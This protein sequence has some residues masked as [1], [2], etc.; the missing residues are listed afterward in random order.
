VA[1]PNDNAYIEALHSNL[2][3]DVIDRFESESIFHAQM[4]ID[5]YYKWY[6][7][8]RRH[9]SLNGQTPETVWNNYNPIPF[10]NEKLPNYL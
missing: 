6:N 2:Q 3:R 4:V 8:K 1:T 5:W 7:E 9:W 10:E